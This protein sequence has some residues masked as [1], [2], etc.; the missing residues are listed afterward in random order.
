MVLLITAIASLVILVSPTFAFHAAAPSALQIITPKCHDNFAPRHRRRH[1]F[2]TTILQ[3]SP[4]EEMRNRALMETRS[5]PTND[6]RMDPLIASLTRD[7]SDSANVPTRQVPLFGEVPADGNLALL[8]P[9]ATIAILGFL[10]SIFVAFNSRDAI[11]QSL[12]SVELPKM[13]YTPTV[14]EEGKCRGLCSSQDEDLDGLRSF[15]ESISKKD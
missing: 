9:A 1:T 10:L 2:T 7:D 14:I 11:V 5:P 6:A 13:E 8:I 15:M 3:M 4:E 12:S